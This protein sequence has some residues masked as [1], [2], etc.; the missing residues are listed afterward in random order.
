MMEITESDVAGLHV[1]ALE[2]RLD[3]ETAPAV[4]R[5]LLDLL[6]RS[7]V[8]LDMT[9]VRFV[10]SAGLRVLLKAA[11]TAKSLGTGFAVYGLQPAVREVYAISGFDR[12]VIPHVSR[13]EAVSALR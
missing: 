9:A 11:K 8:V 5:Q 2:G 1:A 12:I 3:T 7:R 10:S 6:G 13:D 4:E